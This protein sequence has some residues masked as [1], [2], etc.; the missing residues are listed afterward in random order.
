MSKDFNAE[1]TTVAASVVERFVGA[2]RACDTAAAVDNFYQE[3]SQLD[4]VKQIEVLAAVE[5]DFVCEMKQDELNEDDMQ[6]I[7]QEISAVRSGLASLEELLQDDPDTVLRDTQARVL[8]L[9]HMSAIRGKDALHPVT[10]SYLGKIEQLEEGAYNDPLR[11]MEIFVETAFEANKADK[12]LVPNPLRQ[13]KLQVQAASMSDEERKSFVSRACNL[14]SMEEVNVFLSNLALLDSK[15]RFSILTEAC[16]VLKKEAF[17]DY[18]EECEIWKELAASVNG[19]QVAAYA[20]ILP[21]LQA[22]VAFLDRASDMLGIDLLDKPLQLL[23]ERMA[24]LSDDQFNDVRE[25]M[26]LRVSVV[27]TMQVQ[28][29]KPVNP[30]RQRKLGK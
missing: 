14:S 26:K 5:A 23:L 8:L 24:V 6:E 19:A 16:A 21:H 30:V 22:Q 7:R 13:R 9:G 11:M 3:L 12:P 27:E 29:I 18:P 20:E 25:H 4:S 15:D 10:Q 2:A 1:P 17:P 28:D